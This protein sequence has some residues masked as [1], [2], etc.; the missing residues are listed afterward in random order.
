MYHFIVRRIL[1]KA[2]RDINEGAYERI[3]PQ[4]AVR[5]RHAMF[6]HHALA[7]ERHTLA[8]TTQWYARLR[9]LL[10]DLQF[11]V[12]GI[13]V[14]G[15]PWRTLA[16]V[17]WNDR[18]TLPDGTTGSN[19]GVHEFVLSWGRVQ[20]LLVHCDTSRLEEYCARIASAGIP[21]ALAAPLSDSV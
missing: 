11:E 5:H 9:R 4:F 19:Q 14:A 15:W 7:G 21:E 3:L 8:T 18:F 6:G 13:A 1:G 2:F 12:R 10:P 20:S 16:L 17:A